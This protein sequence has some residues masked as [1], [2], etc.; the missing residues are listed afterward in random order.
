MNNITI[1]HHQKL[2]RV[3]ACVALVFNEDYNGL[4]GFRDPKTKAQ[5]AYVAKKITGY[6]DGVISTFYRINTSY[7]VNCF[8]DVEIEIALDDDLLV[9]CETVANLWKLITRSE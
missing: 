7:M 1:T 5:A 3:T 6:G 9:K 8:E 4:R 2:A